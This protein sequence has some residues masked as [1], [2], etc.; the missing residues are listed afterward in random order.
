MGITITVVKGHEPMLYE[1][2]SVIVGPFFIF[3]TV[4]M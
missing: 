3:T 1:A 4:K 2:I